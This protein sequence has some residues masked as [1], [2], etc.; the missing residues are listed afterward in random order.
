MLLISVAKFDSSFVD[1]R[2]YE[3]AEAAEPPVEHARVG[4]VVEQWKQDRDLVIFAA[5]GCICKIGKANDLDRK[6]V[7]QN[8]G[9]LQPVIQHLG[10]LALITLFFNLNPF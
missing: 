4:R 7:C 3:M 5:R 2:A 8:E 10:P 9:V 1:Q 6:E